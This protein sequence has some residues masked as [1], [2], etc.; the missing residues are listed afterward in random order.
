MGGAMLKSWLSSDINAAFSVIDRHVSVDEVDAPIFRCIEDAQESLE[1][2]QYVILAVKPQ[3]MK[4]ICHEAKSFIPQQCCILSIAAGQTLANFE[5]Y[6]SNQQPII[7]IMPNTPSSIGSGMS[8]AIKNKVANSG[9]AEITNQLLS[10]TGKYE[11]IEDE[12]Q[13][14]AV[15]A[16]SGSGPAYIFYFIEALAKAGEE[17]GLAKD[18]SMTLARQTVIGS[19]QLAAEDSNTHASTLRQNVTSPGGTTAAALD[20]LMNGEFQNILNKAVNAAKKRGK[21]LSS[22]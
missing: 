13:M 18:L 7:R 10:K 21:E 11:W 20:V 9:H 14:D 22:S 17:A 12:S 2:A 5:S 16:I 19:A 6:F 15:T 8:V 4:E 3:K 1:N